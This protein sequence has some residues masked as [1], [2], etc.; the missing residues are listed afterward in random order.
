MSFAVY[1]G[2][3]HNDGEVDL[4]QMTIRYNQSPRGRRK[5]KTITMNLKG[6]LYGTGTTLLGYI[7]SLINAYAN[8][9]QDWALYYDSSTITRHRLQNDSSCVSGVKVLYRSWDGGPEQLAT[10]RSYSIVLQAEYAEAD[11]QLLHWEETLMLRG[12]CGPRVEVVDTIDGPVDLQLLPATSQRIVQRGRALGYLGYVLPP[13]PIFP[14]IE[15]QDQR[16]V[17]YGAPRFAGLLFTDYPSEWTYYM[18][19]GVP[20]EAVPIPR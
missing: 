13:G 19:S 1:G 17:E 3:Q 14:A 4:T 18:T 2:F 16:I 9:Y 10:V 8:D 5:S 11:S 15:H 12:N 7:D 6:E 20:Q